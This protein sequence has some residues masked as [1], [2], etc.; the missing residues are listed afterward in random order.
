M[1]NLF[2]AEKQQKYSAAACH[3]FGRKKHSASV[4]FWGFEER[5]V[6]ILGDLISSQRCGGRYG[7]GSGDGSGSGKDNS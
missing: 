5:E 3:C 4:G 2:E 6:I 7:S 1:E